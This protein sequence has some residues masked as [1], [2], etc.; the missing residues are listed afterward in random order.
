MAWQLAGLNPYTN[1]PEGVIYQKLFTGSPIL[2]QV[3][4][5]G[6]IQ[7]GIK[8]AETINIIST[9]AVWQD[10]GCDVVPSG[11]T[12]ITQRTITVGKVT[13]K[14]KFCESQLEPYYTQKSLAAGSEYDALTFK[15]EIVD[16]MLG[17]TAKRLATSIWQGD[18][19]SINEYL[20]KFDGLIKLI[21]AA[22][23]GGTFSGTAWLESNSRV[24]MKG[25]AALVIANQDVYQGGATNIKFYCS[26][27]VAAA[28]RWKLIADNVGYAGAYN[29]DGKLFVEGTTIEV[30]ED[31]GLAGTNY[32]FAIEPDNVRFG[33]DLENEQEEV[34]DWYDPNTQHLYVQSSFKFGVN[35]AFPTRIFKYL[36]V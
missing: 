14:L 2:E 9:D 15:N 28:Y 10:Q 19:N 27:A 8:S 36:G 6:G 20:N 5:A 7:T 24:V 35:F 26:P 22:T 1:E 34:R 18:T 25:L 3:K 21:N 23:I 11:D 30:I 12:S 29:P 16:E 32:I 31:I 17:K 33:T 13:Q 4:A